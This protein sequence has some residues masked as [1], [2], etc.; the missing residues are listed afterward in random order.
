VFCAAFSNF[1]RSFSCKQV[2]EVWYFSR[3]PSPSRCREAIGLNLLSDLN[4]GRHQTFFGIAGAGI[5]GSDVIPFPQHPTLDY[6]VALA[7]ADREAGIPKA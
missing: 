2:A 7:P 5:E 3:R 6:S 1:A 4:K